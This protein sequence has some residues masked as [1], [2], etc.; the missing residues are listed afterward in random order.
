M[1]ALIVIPKWPNFIDCIKMLKQKK[2]FLIIFTI[3]L[4]T[5]SDKEH[6]LVITFHNETMSCVVNI[7]QCL[8]YLYITEFHIFIDAHENNK[9]Q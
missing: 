3:L 7:L 5:K 1:F 9:S 4:K 2:I 6:V 8:R